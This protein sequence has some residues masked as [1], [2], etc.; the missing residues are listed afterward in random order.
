MRV[1]LAD[2]QPDVRSAI[3]LILEER[4]GIEVISEVSKSGDLL[5]EIRRCCPDV[6]FLDWELP[7]IGS[8]ELVPLLRA[9]CPRLSVIALSSSPQVKQAALRA[10]VHEFICKSDPPESFLIAVHHCHEEK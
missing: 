3:R 7:G 10:G 4:P 9:L 1:I 2:D 8:E 5:P 6:I